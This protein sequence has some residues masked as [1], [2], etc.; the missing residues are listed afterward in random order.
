MPSLLRGVTGVGAH[1]EPEQSRGKLLPIT[2]SPDAAHKQGGCS[3]CH[4]GVG[5]ADKCITSAHPPFPG[6]AS[7]AAA[8]CVTVSLS[9]LLC[10][11]VLAHAAGPRC[12]PG[13]RAVTG[14]GICNTG[15]QGGPTKGHAHSARDPQ[16]PGVP[17]EGETVL[18]WCRDSPQSPLGVGAPSPLCPAHKH[19][20]DTL[21]SP[22]P[23]GTLWG[24]PVSLR[25]V[26][27][28]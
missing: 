15:H 12:C 7:V 8:P 5:T 22:G 23:V 2:C 6:R 27:P 1:P 9:S 28:L 19:C 11:G 20:G 14:T 13:H 18:P 16:G 24:C 26:G 3:P 25:T 17:W 10:H 4:K 21:F